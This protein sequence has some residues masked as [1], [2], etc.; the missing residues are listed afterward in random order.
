MLPASSSFRERTTEGREDIIVLDPEGEPN[1]VLRNRRYRNLLLHYAPIFIAQGG[2]VRPFGERLRSVA[3]SSDKQF[4]EYMKSGDG[5]L[6]ILERDAHM[7][8]SP[9][10]EPFIS[11]HISRISHGLHG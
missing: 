3:N 11:G 7:P 4:A 5:V 1:G 8:A 10:R 2:L 9:G 6:R